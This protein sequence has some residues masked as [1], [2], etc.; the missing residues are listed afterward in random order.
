MNEQTKVSFN[1]DTKLYQ[2][3]KNLGVSL[4]HSSTTETINYLLRK[5]VFLEKE[6]V[7][8]SQ[9]QLYFREELDKLT[10]KLSDQISFS[11]ED[12]D[13]PTLDNL[14][15]L[16]SRANKIALANLIATSNAVAN[17]PEEAIEI[18]EEALQGAYSIEG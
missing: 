7:L 6:D 16:S 12:I 15:R 3:I 1:I 13:I 11:L 5:G 10:Q 18:R 17:N 2:E 4:S 8:A 9:T 14:E